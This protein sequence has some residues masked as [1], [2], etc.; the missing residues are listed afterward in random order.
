MEKTMSIDAI[1]R[2]L[3]SMEESMVTKEE[4]NS[5]LE[6]IMILSNDETMNQIRES[7]E[8]IKSGKIKKINSVSDM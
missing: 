5:T 1:Y 7:E 6:T 8:D 2:K 3:K 4:L